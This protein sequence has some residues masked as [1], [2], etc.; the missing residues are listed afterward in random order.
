MMVKYCESGKMIVGDEN[1][2]ENRGEKSLLS[3]IFWL[4][5]IKQL[6]TLVSQVR[7]LLKTQRFASE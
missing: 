3:K 4:I 2:L 6:L 7:R 1:P 5:K